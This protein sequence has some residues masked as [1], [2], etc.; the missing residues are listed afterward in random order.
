MN[1]TY[2][3]GM[4]GTVV[5]TCNIPNAA[6]CTCDQDDFIFELC[7]HFQGLFFSPAEMANTKPVTSVSIAEKWGENQA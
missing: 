7:R 3:R 4:M 2:E 5:K 1:W 6:P